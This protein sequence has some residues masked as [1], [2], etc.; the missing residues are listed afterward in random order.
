MPQGILSCYWPLWGAEFEGD[1]AGLVGGNVIACVPF[2][3]EWREIQNQEVVLSRETSGGAGTPYPE[4]PLCLVVMEPLL[5]GEDL[6]AAMARVGSKMLREAR[7]AV[8]V[9]RLLRP[10][11]FL[12]PTIA[13]TCFA[14]AGEEWQLQRFPGPYRQAFSIGAGTAP[15]LSYRLNIDDLTTR[16]GI[17]G[18]TAALWALLTEFRRISGNASV[19]IAIENFDRSFGLNLWP[20][21]RLAFL[22]IAMDAILGGMSTMRIGKV[23]LRRK[24]FRRR[25][26]SALIV[27]RMSVIDGNT[28]AEWLDSPFGGRGL[29]NAIAHGGQHTIGDGIEQVPERVQRVLRLLLRQYLSFAIRWAENTATV[30]ERFDLPPCCS[31]S[32]AY[33]KVLEAR[34]WGIDEAND[35]LACNIDLE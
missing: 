15:L 25:V 5:F 24:S 19:E 16:S 31:L 7:N 18:S 14:I 12:D 20:M 32:G 22:F 23:L 35:L 30:S 21:D 4:P 9:L 11:W 27:S 2:E 6:G 8:L 33:N 29:R 28:E 13:E 1:G 34:A 26:A 3:D 10:G 17:P